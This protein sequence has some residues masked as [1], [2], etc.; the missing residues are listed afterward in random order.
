MPLA[1][2]QSTAAALSELEDA[3]SDGRNLRDL[4]LTFRR[5]STGEDLLTVGGR[6]DRTA[7]AFID[8]DPADLCAAIVGVNENQVAVVECFREWLTARINGGPR[9]RLLLTG[10]N[11]RGG[12]S[13][14]VT[15]LTIAAAIALPD[16]ICWLVSPNLSKRDELERYVKRITLPAW[17]TYRGMPVYRFGLSNGSTIQ[18]ITGDTADALKRGEADVIAY[19]EPQDCTVDVLTYGAPAIIDRGGLLLFA[20][21]PSRRK[22]GEWFTN[23]RNSILA[24]EYAHGAFIDVPAERNENIDQSARADIGELM[25]LADPKAAAADDLGLW[26]PVGDRAYNEFRKRAEGGKRS[27]LATVPDIGDVTAAVLRRKGVTSA[28]YRYIVGADFQIH[29]F[30]AGIAFQAFGDPARPIYW[31]VGE[32][33]TSE[34]EEDFIDDLIEAG[35]DA[36]NSIAIGDA[37]GTWQ[38]GAHRRGKTSF[39]FFK[40][41]R[42]RIEAPRV[43]RDENRHPR[44]PDV[45]DRVGLVNR[46]L[47]QGRFMIDPVRCPRLVE[48]LHECEAKDGRPTGRHAHA[49]DAAG[50]GLF[51]MEPP[52]RRR[53]VMDP[54]KILD[55]G[56]GRL[57]PI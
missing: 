31:A 27:N 29:P 47:A 1:S 25:Q 28:R 50:Y 48:A 14:I 40:G 49:T 5:K 34:H 43:S 4:C 39:D 26:L 51:W 37:S 9:K 55:R 13:Y 36:D 12:K 52:P 24:G 15:A 46:L 54:S 30:H 32:V 21:N 17:R 19:N 57:T 44:N 56:A 42:Y 45:E 33:Y 3:L 22:K 20:G 38:D 35:F 6:W 16:S 41:R 2:Y 11:R 10:G 53:V 18:S 8:P 23:L 7:A